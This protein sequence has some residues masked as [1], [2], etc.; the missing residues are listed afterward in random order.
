MSAISRCD[1]I[2]SSELI[3]PVTPSQSLSAVHPKPDIAEPHFR[4]NRIGYRDWPKNAFAYDN[5][6]AIRSFYGCP[7]RAPLLL[8][9]LT[10]ATGNG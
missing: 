2:L 10:S 9:L 8:P 6:D 4:A 5:A 7:I 3:F 1:L